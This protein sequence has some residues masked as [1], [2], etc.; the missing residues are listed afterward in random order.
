MSDF[1]DEAL[2]NQPAQPGRQ[3]PASEGQL[4]RLADQVQKAAVLS[5]LRF[6]SG[7]NQGFDLVWNNPEGYTPEQVVEA[8]GTQ[9]S[10][11]FR[12][13]A[14]TVQFL[15]GQSPE[16]LR[17]VGMPPSDVTITHNPDGTVT[18]TRDGG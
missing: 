11:V 8:L 15:A 16:A 14:A 6:I 1:L 13:H 10:A 18:L 2:A 7:V 3:D 4:G 12:R 17:L 5:T 9:A